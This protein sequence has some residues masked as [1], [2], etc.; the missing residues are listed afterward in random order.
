MSD[1]RF[2]LDTS[3][4]IYAVDARDKN[5]HRTASDIIRGASARDC[6]LTNQVVCEF[7]AV[8]TRKMRMPPSEA[9][10]QG[11]DWMVLFPGVETTREAIRVALAEAKSGRLSFWDAL[12]LAAAEQAGCVVA[13]S[14]DMA[15]GTRLS[16]LVV[17]APFASGGVSE[18]AT[19]LIRAH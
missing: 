18:I 13:L 10:A 5:K 6:W 9:A 12:L 8:A 4:L 19:R 14:E 15:D 16:N 7:F 2:T 1:E 3:I 17:R 11:R